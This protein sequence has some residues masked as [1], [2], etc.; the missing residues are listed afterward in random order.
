MSKMKSCLKLPAIVVIVVIMGCGARYGLYNPK[1]D[2]EPQADYAGLKTYN[3]L[4]PKIGEG[5]EQIVVDDIKSTANEQ[6]AEKGY[7][8]VTDS[9]DFSI[10]LHLDIKSQISYRTY[11]GGAT[12]G[13]P[14]TIQQIH[15]EEGR[16]LLDILD[17][18]SMQLIWRGSIKAEVI[19]DPT[20]TERKNRINAAVKQI[21]SKFPP[22]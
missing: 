7:E 20:A 13:G 4:E 15:Y 10:A 21:L 12:I 19:R 18:A 16:V 5:I 8:L 1:W 3:W 17:N 2:Y 9:P 22:D 14:S 11:T 6:L